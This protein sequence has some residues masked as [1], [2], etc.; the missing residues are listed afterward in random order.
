MLIIFLLCAFVQSLICFEC[1][2]H[3]FICQTSLNIRYRLPMMTHNDGPVYPYRGKL[4]HYNVTDPSKALPVSVNDIITADGQEDSFKLVLSV[5]DSL[6]GPPIIVYQGQKVIIRVNNYLGSEAVTVHWHGVDQAGTPWMDGVP[7]ITQCPI[8]P[9]QTFTYRFTVRN[10]GTF[11]YHSHI[12]HQRLNGLFGPFIVREKSPNPIPE[13]ILQV[14]EWNHEYNGDIDEALKLC[15]GV[16]RHRRR[17]PNSEQ[18]DRVPFMIYNTHSGLI[19]GRGRFWSNSTSHNEAPLDIFNV[20]AGKK[21]LFRVI[22]TG[23]LF[24]WRI[25]V[26]GHNITIVES[27]GFKIEPVVVESVVV[28]P[29]ERYNFILETNQRPDNYWIRGETLDRRFAKKAEAI[30]NY[31]GVPV[32]EPVSEKTVC[33]PDSRCA[34]VNCPFPFYPENKNVTCTRLTDLKSI[35]NLKTP[36]AEKSRF[37]EYFLNFA[38]PGRYGKKEDP[39]INGKIFV[40]PTVSAL[41]Q[42]GEITHH[43]TN[44]T[45]GEG[46]LCKCFHSLTID[47][48]EIIQLVLLSAGNGRGDDHPVH[49][50][51]HSFFVLKIG[52]GKYNETSG[53]L[54]GDT[55]DIDCRGSMCNNATWRNSSWLMGNVPGITENGAVLKDTVNVP[56]G[57]YVIIRFPAS[58]PG[59]WILHCHVDQHANDG[60]AMVLNETY[61]HI[62]NPPANV[63][64]CRNFL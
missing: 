41:T 35:L 39:S 42:S 6:P 16:Y 59:I 40:P 48:G 7:F 3:A 17:L 12:G 19:N 32:S 33:S 52:Y 18:L 2:Q 44:D 46:K 51:G 4:Y 28:T 5:N 1:D 37:K 9:G 56:A 64:V 10:P 14:F 58:N 55:D 15:Q 47:S 8:F 29:G 31:N 53:T 23:T 38:F 11:W 60:M 57:G 63:P 61:A 20:D 50:H 62:P 34:V 49:V 43:C 13:H 27:D 36:R 45:C 26:D 25:S 54:I 22:G 30:L 24:P 21:Y